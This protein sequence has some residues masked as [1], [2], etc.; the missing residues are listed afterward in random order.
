MISG[1]SLKAAR[2]A[3][4]NDLVWL[5]TSRWF[6]NRNDV[7]LLL[8]V[9]GMNQ[10]CQRRALAGTGRTGNQNQPFGNVNQPGQLF[11]EIQLLNRFDFF[12]NQTKNRGHPMSL[13]KDVHAKTTNPGKRVAQI[14]IQ[15]I[16]K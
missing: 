6:F 7:G 11:R 16:F 13:H 10:R 12:R 3:L 14:Q 1:S 9:D 5:A 4:L 8:N 2:K 15:I